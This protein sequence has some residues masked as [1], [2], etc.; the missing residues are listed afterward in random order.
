MNWWTQEDGD[1]AWQQ[2]MC[3]E[4]EQAEE[5][6]FIKAMQKIT[7]LRYLKEIKDAG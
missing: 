2:K 3:E 5:D 1:S 4:A 7:E 6:A